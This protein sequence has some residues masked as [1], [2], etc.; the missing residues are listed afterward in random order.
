MVHSECIKGSFR[1]DLGCN[2]CAF[3]CIQ[4]VFRVYL[5]YIYGPFKVYLVGV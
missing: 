4:G 1:T 5:G 2:W 3:W